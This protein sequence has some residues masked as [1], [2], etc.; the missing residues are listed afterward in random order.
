MLCQDRLRD[1]N[2]A[3]GNYEEL[4][5]AVDQE[6]RESVPE[7]VKVEMVKKVLQV[8]RGMVED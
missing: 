8:L 5:M 3:A 2:A 6:A 1:R 7:A 4:R